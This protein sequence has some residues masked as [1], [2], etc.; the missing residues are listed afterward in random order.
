[1]DTVILIL[2][3]FAGYFTHVYRDYQRFKE[4]M[5]LGVYLRLVK[6]DMAV[7]F[8]LTL[9]FCAILYDLGQLTPGAA[10]AC[11]Y[12]GESLIRY[13]NLKGDATNDNGES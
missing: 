10:F 5:P 9:S 12:S 11:G 13:L 8:I 7:T 3:A 6:G 1:M 2:L 4:E